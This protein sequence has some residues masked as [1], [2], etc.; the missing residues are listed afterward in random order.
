[1]SD[2]LEVSI[3]A[4][5][6]QSMY[7]R[8]DELHAKWPVA[9]DEPREVG[10]LSSGEFVALALACGHEKLLRSPMSSFLMLDGWLQRWVLRHRGMPNMIGSRIGVDCFL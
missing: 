9:E 8:L 6:Q 2:E 1:M 5:W 3:D 7:R 4:Q 10:P